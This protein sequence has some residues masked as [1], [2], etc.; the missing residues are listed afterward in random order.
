MIVE[1]VPTTERII[2]TNEMTAR[3]SPASPFWEVDNVRVHIRGGYRISE[4]G[5]GGGGPGNC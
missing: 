1:R 5:G 3:M 2:P 4:R